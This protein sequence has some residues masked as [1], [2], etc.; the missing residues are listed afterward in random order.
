[1]VKLFFRILIAVFLLLV[2]S[3]IY[4]KIV[5]FIYLR[6]WGFDL[7]S[8][9][10]WLAIPDRWGKGW[11]IDTPEEFF[12]FF[13]MLLIVI[14]FVIGYIIVV[15][16]PYVKIV[17]WPFRKLRDNRRMEKRRRQDAFP[18]IEKMISDL[19]A[20]K[21]KGGKIS[22]SKMPPPMHTVSIPE[23]GKNQPP[24][25][26]SKT[27]KERGKA[28]KDILDSFKTQKDETLELPKRKTAPEYTD[29]SGFREDDYIKPKD[30]VT[31]SFSPETFDDSHEKAMAEFLEEPK[32]ISRVDMKYETLMLAEKVGLNIVQ[33]LRIGKDIVDFAVLA[34]GEVYLINLEPVGKEWVADET[35][36]DDDEPLW[37]SE[38][39]YDV[40]PVFRLNRAANY[41]DEV[42]QDI[43]DG[44]PDSIEVK[45]ILLIGGASV[46]NYADIK[47]VWD[48]YS[49]LS[50]RLSTGRPPEVPELSSF[51]RKLAEKGS[52]PESV[53]DMIY[54][55]FVAVE[56]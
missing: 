13:G 47:P 10:S 53:T 14:V 21:G 11:V 4:A 23:T 52:D 51:L 43:T 31:K 50:F 40:S 44:Y 20:K 29:Y 2:W 26:A 56:P 30:E 38:S 39:K 3:V 12:F 46:L 34:K 1:M 16:L 27:N 18:G 15:K 22:K 8:T 41:F 55:A 42:L 35:S 6:I 28:E 9:Y 36:F 49:V 19:Q 33:D 32:V 7:F 5:Q 54:T 48:S 45:K 24:L 17:T 25:Y 37:F